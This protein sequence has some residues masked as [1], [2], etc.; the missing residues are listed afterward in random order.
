MPRICSKEV[1]ALL[2]LLAIVVGAARSNALHGASPARQEA[3]SSAKPAP[4]PLDYEV[5]KARIEPIF[6]KN[7]PGHARC[8]S[9]H[10]SG[11]GP[12]YLVPLSPGATAWNEEQSR[13]IFENVSKLV[14]RD[15]PMNSKLLLR[16]LSP[17]AGGDLVWEHSGGRQ[18]QSKDDPDWQ[19]MAA[20][21]GAK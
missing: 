12:Q 14:D 4:P 16:P 17:L 13:Q 11:N 5:F 21:A 8:Y 20:W 9:C 10:G 2:L 19:A 18:F 15:N 1:A 6:L 7:R 3:P